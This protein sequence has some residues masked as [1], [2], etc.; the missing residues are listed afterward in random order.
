MYRNFDFSLNL[1]YNLLIDYV[2]ILSFD[3]IF[4]NNWL[5]YYFFNFSLNNLFYI[6]FN[7]SFYWIVYYFFNYNFLLDVTF[8]WFF[9]NNFIGLFNNNLFDYR[10]FNQNIN[11]FLNYS[12]THY[13]IRLI[14]INRSLNI[15]LFLRDV[16]NTRRNCSLR[17]D[18]P[19]LIIL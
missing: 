7:Y 2:F 13:S 5:L 17:S 18:R 8:N 10:S 9:Y 14:N 19:F 6:C 4:N 16:L 11:F 1:I 12:F 3:D 15:S